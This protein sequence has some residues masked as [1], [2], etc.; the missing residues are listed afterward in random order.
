MADLDNELVKTFVIAAHSDLPTVQK[1]LAEQPDLL[2]V[3]YDWGPG[4]RETGIGAAA[5]VGD[6]AI[7]EFF[8]ARG[9]PSNICVAAMLGRTDEVRQALNNDPS[10]ANA[11]GAHGISV[12]FH[13]AMSGNIEIAGLLLAAGCHEGFNW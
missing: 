1:M 12:L 4:G 5:H 2:N 11:R 6:R 3:E 7:A 10:L 13:A 8:L 9:V